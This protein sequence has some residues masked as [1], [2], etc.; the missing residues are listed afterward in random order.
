MRKLLLIF[1]GGIM[2]GGCQKDNN[3]SDDNNAN[4]GT[5]TDASG[6]T[7]PTVKIGNQVWMAENLRTTKYRDGSNIPIITSHTQW[8]INFNNGIPLKNPMM[9]WLNNDDV[10]YA[11]NKYG[12]LY[13]WYSI[14]ST[15][16]GNK[17]VCPTGWHVPSDAEWT[18]LIDFLG[19]ESVAGGKMK[20]TGTKYWLS[21]NTGANNSSGF[22]GL[23]AG[24]RG[25]VDGEFVSNNDYGDFWSSTEGTSSLSAVLRGIGYNSSEI[26]RLDYV[27]K[28]NGLSVRCIKD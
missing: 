10:T 16:N 7:Y 20:S 23:P 2:F 22:S 18:I 21:P 1:L 5:V 11:S 8:A 24:A 19:G 9:C 26:Y 13:N 6:N 27:F 15:A 12:A 3:S 17:N 4:T 28:N 14:N 25:G